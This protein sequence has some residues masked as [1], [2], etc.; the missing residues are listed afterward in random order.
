[1]NIIIN[2]TETDYPDERIGYDD[3]AAFVAIEEQWQPPL[4]VLSITY[5][6]RGPHY[7][8]DGILAPNDK[9]I[10]PAPGMRFSAN[11]TGAA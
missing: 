9:P 4:P 11:V 2:G 1:M 6:W 7:T 8:R 3:V 5:S 10:K